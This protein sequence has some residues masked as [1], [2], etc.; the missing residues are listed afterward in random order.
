MKYRLNNSVFIKGLINKFNYSRDFLTAYLN[1]STRSITNYLNDQKL[2]KNV[3][4]KLITLLE[5]ENINPFSLI[6]FDDK[7]HLYHA[8]KEGINGKI[9]V[10][11]NS[12][13]QLDFGE[14]FYLSESFRTALS[15]VDHYPSPT[16]YR[17]KRKQILNHNKYV[18]SENKVDVRNW[19]LLIGLNRRKIIR[20][21]EELFI[22]EYY[23]KLIGNYPIL[24][25]KIADSYNFAIMDAFFLNIYDINQVNLALKCVDIGNQIVIKDQKIIDEIDEYDEITLDKDLL[26]YFK[27]Y[28]IKKTKELKAKTQTYL[29]KL[30]KMNQ[31]YIHLY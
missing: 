2:T 5:N 19:V 15:Y 24:I 29:I 20:E 31:E 3:F 11:Y 7:N 10:H 8:S 13:H 28:H 6:D 16:I 9:S 21:N 23:S 27:E 12:S 30:I 22:K 4:K 25:G 18:F 14:G 17:F 1:V 26:E